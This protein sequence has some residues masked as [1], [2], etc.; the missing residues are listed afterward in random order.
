MAYGLPYKHEDSTVTINLVDVQLQQDFLQERF[1]MMTILKEER[2]EY[3]KGK[4][5]DLQLLLNRKGIIFKPIEEKTLE[6]SQNKQHPQLKFA[7]KVQGYAQK[8]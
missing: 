5:L 2:V 1:E 3:R 8:G 4:K 6:M 7:R